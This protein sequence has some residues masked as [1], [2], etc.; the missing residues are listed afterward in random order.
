MTPPFLNALG[1]CCLPTLFP[2][3]NMLQLT[4]FTIWNYPIQFLVWLFSLVCKPRDRK[5][6]VCPVITICPSTWCTCWWAPASG[7]HTHAADEE[8]GSEGSAKHLHQGYTVG[9]QLEPMLYMW[10]LK[11]VFGSLEPKYY[12]IV[13]RILLG[14]T[15]QKARFAR[16]HWTLSHQAL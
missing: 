2:A 9:K 6:L 10:R 4:H 16:R 7:W 12:V 13:G 15:I 11:G 14:H 8:T 5:E 1:P 3:S